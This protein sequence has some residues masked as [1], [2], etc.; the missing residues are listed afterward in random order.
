MNMFDN[1][2]NE[3]Y[4][5]LFLFIYF[6][7]F[8]FSKLK[9]GRNYICFFMGVVL[10][11][12]LCFRDLS[13]GLNDTKE[14]Y[15]PMYSLAGEYTWNTLYSSIISQYTSRTFI[16]IMKVCYI[17]F[18]GNFRAFLI[19]TSAWFVF[20]FEYLIFKYSK[21]TL[22]ANLL[23]VAVLYP[24]GFYLIRQC[25]SMGFLALATGLFWENKYIKSALFSLIAIFIHSIAFV[26]IASML[27]LIFVLK[28]TNIK[29]QNIN[30]FVLAITFLI[31][32]RPSLF[33]ELLYFLPEGSK[34]SNLLGLNLY[35][36]GNIWWRPLIL[37]IMISIYLAKRYHNSDNLSTQL[38]VSSSFL[39][40]LFISS[41]NIIQDMVRISY[42][43]VAP[44]VVLIGN[45]FNIMSFEKNKVS[46]YKNKVSFYIVVFVSLIYSFAISL[47]NNNIIYW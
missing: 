33:Y 18:W 7:I 2:T 9:N 12:G 26:F 42:Y 41:T 1:I 46:F 10:F 23:F 37:Q 27:I 32:L 47:P 44:Y 40:L 30:G 20:S 13:Q 3:I 19:I 28:K 11:L 14:V 22:I 39:S 24:Y 8:V 35:S 16:T 5:L 21:N 31:I 15:L 6:L 38:A 45:T 25:I 17:I 34:Y 29:V 4:I 36:S 43:F